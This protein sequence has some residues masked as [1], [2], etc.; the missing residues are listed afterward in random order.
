MQRN[1][2]DAPWGWAST[3]DEFLEADRLEVLESLKTHL[4]MRFPKFDLEQSQISA[5]IRTIAV[6]Q[7][8][9]KGMTEF[10]RGSES[11][12][13]FEYELPGEGGRRPDVT[14][15]TPTQHV[16]VIE[17]KNRNKLHTPDINQAVQYR[18]DLTSYHSET[19]PD[20]TQAYVAILDTGEGQQNV[21][22]QEIATLHQDENGFDPLLTD[23]R[24]ALDQQSNYEPTEWLEADYRPMPE[25][26]DAV[27]ETF[28]EG[29][30]S[31]IKDYHRASNVEDAISHI[32]Q[33]AEQAAS[34]Q[35]HILILITGAPGS[36]KTMVGLQSSIL[37]RDSGYES[38]Y[39]SGNGPLVAVIQDALRRAGADKQSAK[40]IIRPVID[41]KT[42]VTKRSAAPADVYIFDEGQRAWT[43]DKL[44]NFDGNE[45]ELLV[46]VT[47]RR[48][49]GVLVGLIGEGQ[50]I[51]KGEEGDLIAWIRSL[52]RASGAET[53]WE[54]MLPDKEIPDIETSKN[55]T[56]KPTLH[57]ETNIRAK[58][59]DRLH[60]WVDA[61]LAGNSKTAAKIAANLQDGGYTLQVTE[62]RSAAEEYVTTEFHNAGGTKY[63]WLISSKHRDG[64]DPEGMEPPFIEDD[65][66]YGDWFNAPPTESG[67]CCQLEQPVTEFGCQGL[68]IEFSLVFW[69][70]DFTWS[71][72]KWEARDG[73]R[74]YN[75]SPQTPIALTKNVYRVLLTRGRRGM[76]IRCWDTQTRNYLELCGAKHLE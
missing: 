39:L 67:S 17:C 30:L 37:L 29:K 9:L 23:I 2:D 41:F 72:S 32:Q 56:T 50:A 43:S 31:Y 65:G 18:K 74:E 25:L 76:I 73:V 59:A 10:D 7:D 19:S 33:A 38:M 22:D 60:E 71:G 28:Q 20:R 1:A 62:S 63:G 36:G 64:N 53:D 69:G 24:E 12:I 26:T 44:N 70:N 15:V 35:K 68:E 4:K 11:L 27:V 61:V 66:V 45:I 57:L 47:E 42:G 46:D 3:L 75:Q 40:S 48:D 34:E 54:I 16:F 51:H 5:W 58:Y 21:D 13:V 55:V 52:E 8:S 14:I 49:S 6:F